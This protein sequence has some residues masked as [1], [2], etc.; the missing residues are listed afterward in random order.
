MRKIRF[1]VAAR[2][3]QPNLDITTPGEHPMP[4]VRIPTGRAASAP[5]QG[6]AIQDRTGGIFV[7]VV[8]DLG[9][10]PRQQVRV[11]GELADD[12]FGL[13]MVIDVTDV[14][15]HGRG[16]NVRPLPVATG[17]VE[18][19]TE[20]TLVTA[21]FGFTIT[22]DDGSGDVHAFVCA[23]TGIDVSGLSQGQTI[24]VTGFS[25]Q[26][27]DPEVNPRFQSDIKILD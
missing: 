9:F 7:S 26:F 16:P 25:G 23:S 18:E 22:L 8:E 14:K 17:A 3:V 1:Q 24:E 6:F 11:T 21:P 10:A 27:D 12:G 20:G 13:L 15:A 2:F 5:D 4:R 19:A